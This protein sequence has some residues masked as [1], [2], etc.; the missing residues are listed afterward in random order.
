MTHK[1]KTQVC[2]RREGVCPFECVFFTNSYEHVR[3]YAA[4]KIRSGDGH[5]HSHGHGHGQYIAF[6]A[7]VTF[8][9]V[10]KKA[11]DDVAAMN[12]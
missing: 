1:R 6:T 12:H 7:T 2:A 3:K 8:A 5:A 10:H 9:E 11:L 4:C